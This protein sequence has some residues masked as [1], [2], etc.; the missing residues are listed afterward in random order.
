MSTLQRESAPKDGFLP[1]LLPQHENAAGDYVATGENNP[2]PVLLQLVKGMLPVQFQETLR[3][4]K[5]EQTHTTAPI[6]SGQ[7]NTGQWV[8]LEGF[9]KLGITVNMGSGVG[10]TITVDFSHDGTTYFT[11]LDI[12]DGTLAKFTSQND[13]PVVAKYGR[14]AIKNKD[15]TAGASKTTNAYLYAKS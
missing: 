6:S 2:L 9:D 14:L 5:T 11:G 7:W 10:M 13:I 8:N 4:Q 15:A 12:Y 1:S 3:T